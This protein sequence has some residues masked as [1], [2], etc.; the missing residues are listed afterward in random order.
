VNVDPTGCELKA[1][2]RDVYTPTPQ[3]LKPPAPRERVSM[4]DVTDFPEQTIVPLMES[5]PYEEGRYRPA[6]LPAF[7]GIYATHMYL[8]RGKTYDWCSC[9][10]SQIGPFCDGQCK[11]IVTRLRPVTFN[12]SESGY[13][14][15]CNCKMCPNAPFS[16]GCTNVLKWAY[17]HHR[18]FWGMTTLGAWWTCVTYWM[19]TFYK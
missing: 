16:N 18:G 13:Y 10:H 7:A 15:L 2:E 6:S 11:W 19:F 1:H 12:V 9:G 8:H 14:K 5:R 3:V 17:K 4:D